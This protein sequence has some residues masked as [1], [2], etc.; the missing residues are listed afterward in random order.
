MSD[1]HYTRD[2]VGLVITSI[3][4][5]G[6]IPYAKIKG[7]GVDLLYLNPADPQVTTAKIKEARGAGFVVG[8]IVFVDTRAESG[9]DA[10]K[11][12]NDY[13]IRL[14]SGDAGV[15]PFLIDAEPSNGSVQFW[16]D[17][18]AAYRAVMPGRVT[19]FTP[20]P[21]KAAVLP[22]NYLLNARFDVKVQGYFGDMSPVD[23]WE[24]GLDWLSVGFPP[25]RIRLFVDGGRKN[26]PPIFYNDSRAR[27]LLPGSIIWNAN[28]LREAGLI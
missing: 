2:H 17:F 26:K 19:D 11:R 24:A 3:S 14:A 21:F 27:N 12:A 20:E 22:V 8:L 10:A 16:L 13:R 7:L 4:S 15:T 9:A 18:I 5:L 1:P 25:E 23:G 28:L 6:S